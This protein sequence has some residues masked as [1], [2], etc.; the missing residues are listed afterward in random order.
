ML[1]IVEEQHPDR[2][3]LFMQ[4]KR[5]GWPILIDSL[6]LLGVSAVPTTL[7]IDERGNV[8][9]INPRPEAFDEFLQESGTESVQ[10]P[11]PGPGPPDVEGLGRLA[12]N[13][14]RPALL[15]YGDA[16][17]LWRDA[18]RLDAAIEAYRKVLEQ[19]PSDGATHFRLGVAYRK[20]YDS[21]LRQEGDFGRAVEE[22][23]A[24]LDIDPNQYIWRRRIQQYGPRLDKPYPFYDWVVTAVA[25]IKERGE[26][27]VPLVVQPD[28]AEFAH[29]I[30]RFESAEGVRQEPDSGA[31]I[32]RDKKGFVR[33]ET[34]V[35]PPQI[36]PG[37]STRVH[38]VFRPN[39]AIKAHWNNEA[40]DMVVWV[41]PPRGWQVDDPYLVF[42]RPPEPVSHEARE[43]EFEIKSP[44]DFKG[45]TTIP[46]YAL[47]YVCEDVD[48]T[49]L[50]RRQDIQ[51]EMSAR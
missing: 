22:W 45:K 50:F 28:G 51:V 47:Y 40:E 37:S 46:A 16:L 18:R 43:V 32:H 20:R 14:D 25:Q 49:C 3:R 6:D 2:T 21:E 38:L 33:L 11:T 19:D 13:E 31:R 5:M 41:Q 4:W 35:V 1:G 10:P 30:R 42:P 12:Q 29:P 48:G 8:R 15:A 44:P 39:P 24:A 7:L 9:A 36:S 26:E 27:P 17:V 23:S 34:T